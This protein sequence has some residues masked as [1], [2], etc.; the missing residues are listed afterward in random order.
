MNYT[1]HLIE[2]GTLYFIDFN[3]DLFKIVCKMSGKAYSANETPDIEN[4]ALTTVSIG[5]RTPFMF[6]DNACYAYPE[7]VGTAIYTNETKRY[8]DQIKIFKVL[9]RERTFWACFDDQSWNV[10]KKL[11]S[12]NKC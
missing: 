4:A 5:I 6:L 8:F 1:T 10:L 9:A 12:D 3:V 11:E 2:K 7:I